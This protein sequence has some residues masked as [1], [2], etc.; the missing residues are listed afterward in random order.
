[1]GRI[2]EVSQSRIRSR[3]FLKFHTSTHVFV[4]NLAQLHEGKGTL[5]YPRR[6]IWNNI[7]TYLVRSL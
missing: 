4:F 3:R 7:A 6:A 5:V 1:M 2:I